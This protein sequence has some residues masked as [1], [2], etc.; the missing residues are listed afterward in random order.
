MHALARRQVG[1]AATEVLARKESIEIKVLDVRRAV[2][3]SFST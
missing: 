1:Y 2:L 3:F